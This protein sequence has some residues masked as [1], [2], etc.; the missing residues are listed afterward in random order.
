VDSTVS[1]GGGRFRLRFTPDTGA[2]YLLSTR[3]GGIEYFSPPLDAAAAD[4]LVSLFVYDT[5]SSAPVRLAARHVVIPRPGE[6]GSREVLDLFVLA[7]DGRLARVAPDSLSASWASPLPPA[8]EGLEIG[9]GDVSPDAVERRGDT[10]FLGAPIG[11]GEKQLSLQYHL[12][13]NHTAVEIPIGREG[14]PVNVLVEE[15]NAVVSG[16]GLAVADTQMIEGRSFRRW[17][18]E[19]PAGAVIAVRLPGRG[20]ASGYVMAVLVGLVALALAV[21]TRAVLARR[22]VT[23]DGL[24]DQIAALDARYLGREP[25]VELAEWSRYQDDRARLKADL[26][27]RLA[28]RQGGRAG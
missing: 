28:S 3:Y 23:P 8:S 24:I 27:A 17:T 12:P 16:S 6:G 21:A 10:L 20:R 2:I 14:G 7:N 19:V 22:P 1:A 26:E 13:G 18:G 25:E 11:P 9:E 4:S 15:P 5:S